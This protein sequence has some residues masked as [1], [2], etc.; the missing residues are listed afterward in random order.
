MF[1]PDAE[2]VRRCQEA[3]RLAIL[4]IGDP[5]EMR[6]PVVNSP[7]QQSHGHMTRGRG[8]ATHIAADTINAAAGVRARRGQRSAVAT[9]PTAAPVAARNTRKRGAAAISSDSGSSSSAVVASAQLSKKRRTATSTRASNTA[10]D[11]SSS[12]TPVPQTREPTILPK[13]QA[14]SGGA[15]FPIDKESVRAFSAG[16]SRVGE[17]TVTWTKIM[18]MG[19]SSFGA[20]NSHSSYV[21]LPLCPTMESYDQLCS[22]ERD[23][24]A[25]LRL[26][27][28]QYLQIKDALLSGRARRGTFRKREAQGWCRVDVNKTGKIYD[29]FVSLGWLLA[30]PSRG[31]E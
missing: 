9:S 8:K 5:A 19:G 12:G 4:C 7:Q 3:R 13:K 25:T 14:K 6:S 28:V 31:R 30:P 2:E 10:S 29:W 15:P 20:V 11:P 24:C 23:V 26:S 17:Y 21:P 1:V 27:P 18:H 16:T 22:S